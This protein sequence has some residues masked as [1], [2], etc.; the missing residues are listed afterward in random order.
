MWCPPRLPEEQALLV[1]ILQLRGQ[2]HGTQRKSGTLARHGPVSYP[3]LTSSTRRSSSILQ[4][5]VS[6]TSSTWPENQIRRLWLPTSRLVIGCL[7]FG[8]VTLGSSSHL[9]G[10][11]LHLRTCSIRVCGT[12]THRQG[13]LRPAVK[14]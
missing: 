10:D 1:G 8:A 5:D 2:G 4:Q 14:L 7:P 3:Q 6:I 11:S 9:G 12:I 13:L